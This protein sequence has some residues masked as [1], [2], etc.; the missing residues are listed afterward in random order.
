MLRAAAKEAC[1]QT[2]AYASRK[3][4]VV[5]LLCTSAGLSREG[6]QKLASGRGT[7]SGFRIVASR[8]GPAREVAQVKEQVLASCSGIPTVARSHSKLHAAARPPAQL[9]FNWVAAHFPWKGH[10]SQPMQRGFVRIVA[11]ADASLHSP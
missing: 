1:R 3:L 11:S 4:E 5:P 8:A 2:C 7:F 6:A 9:H 10:P